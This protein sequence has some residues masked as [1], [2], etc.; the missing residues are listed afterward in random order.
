[1]FLPFFF[2]STTFCHAL[3]QLALVNPADT[4]CPFSRRGIWWRWLCLRILKCSWKWILGIFFCC[5]K[6]KKSKIE[7]IWI[8]HDL[9]ISCLYGYGMDCYWDF[10]VA[11]YLSHGLSLLVGRSQH[12]KLTTT[13]G[14]DFSPISLK[15]NGISFTLLRRF[16]KFSPLTPNTIVGYFNT[17]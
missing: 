16:S 9:M 13:C 10:L 11:F 12:G 1:M 4:W 7:R 15:G 5:L 14:C 3:T 6:R 8:F 2:I 17:L